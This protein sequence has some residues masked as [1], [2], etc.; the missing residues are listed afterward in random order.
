MDFGQ[1]GIHHQ[2]QADGDGN[3]GRPDRDR[4]IEILHG[5]WEEK[6]DPHTDRHGQEDPQGQEAV[7]EGKSFRTGCFCH[8]TSSISAVVKNV[9]ISASPGTR[10]EAT[11]FSLMTSPGVERIW[12]LHDLGIVG[13]FFD[14]CFH[15]QG[16]GDAR[17]V[18]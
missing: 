9:V 3:I 18:R 13:H 15:A 14:F 17:S 7:E 2:D 6:T 4:G 8:V 11:S 16:I 1:G 5:G 12:V 10:P